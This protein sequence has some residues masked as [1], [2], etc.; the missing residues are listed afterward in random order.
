MSVLQ[1]PG[2]VHREHRRS[3]R[4]RHCSARG[5]TGKHTHTLLH[6]TQTPAAQHTQPAVR[7]YAH[8]ETGCIR[9]EVMQEVRRVILTI[10]AW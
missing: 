9:N 5:E 3:V 4:H 1:R 6:D 10:L 2:V 8:K 7:V